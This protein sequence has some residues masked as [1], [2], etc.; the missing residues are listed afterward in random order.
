MAAGTPVARVACGAM[1][2]VRRPTVG[3]QSVPGCAVPA[4]SA[5]TRLPW[6]YGAAACLN[7]A[8]ASSALAAY[9]SDGPPPM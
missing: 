2:A 9:I 8:T 5:R 4:G 7:S 6:I 1:A 3:R